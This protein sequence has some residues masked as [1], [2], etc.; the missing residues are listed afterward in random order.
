V[1]GPSGRSRHPLYF[2]AHE[3]KYQVLCHNVTEFGGTWLLVQP[4]ESP[5]RISD[6]QDQTLRVDRLLVAAA[7]RNPPPVSSAT[8]LRMILR[9]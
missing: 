7:R 2:Y 5:R 6:R 9:T 3:R 8:I 1:L 4:M